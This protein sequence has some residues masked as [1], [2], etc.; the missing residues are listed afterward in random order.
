VQ[1]DLAQDLA[2]LMMDLKAPYAITTLFIFLSLWS[3][4]L[5]IRKKKPNLIFN[6]Y[7][8]AATALLGVNQYLS[9]EFQPLAPTDSKIAIQAAFSPHQGSTE[10]IIRNI[11]AAR[12]SIRVAAYS[13]T[14]KPIAQA[15]A[16]AH[17]RG[18]DVKVVLDKSQ[19]REQHSVLTSLQIQNIPT[20]INSKYAIMHNKFM[21]LD[22]NTLQTGSFNYTKA[23]EFRNAENIL[24]I[25]QDFRI[26][27]QYF[28]QWQRLWDESEE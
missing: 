11:N 14:S 5:Y 22:N 27:S 6:L 28:K 7:L 16:N 17:N 18:V 15:L 24:V 2:T 19:L 4:R 9:T 13:F 12:Q 25:S 10:L 20:R 1:A 26:I 21:I 23:A 8:I 3:C